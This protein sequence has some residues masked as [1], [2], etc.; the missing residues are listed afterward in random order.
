M[1]KRAKQI[2]IAVLV[3]FSMLFIAACGGNG[4][5]AGGDTGD[6]PEAVADGEVVEI[7]FGN[8]S[9]DSGIAAAYL[10]KEVAERESGGTLQINLFNNN[11][12][13]DD[14]SQIEQTIFGDIHIAVSSSS[15][16]ASMHADLFAFD[17]PFLFFNEAQA[18]TV[19]DGPYG[20]QILADMADIGLKGLGYW[21]NGFRNFTSDHIPVNTPADVAGVTI[22]TM[23]NEIHLAAW[24]AFGANPTPM[25]MTE[26]FTALQQGTI[27]AQE[28]T[29]GTIDGFGLY[30]IQSYISMTGHIYTPFI[31]VMNMDKWNSLNQV[32]QDA[33]MEATRQSID[34]QREFSRNINDEFIERWEEIG[35]TM[36]WPTDTEKAMF[37]VL[38][39]EAGVWDMIRGNMDNPQLLDAM[40]DQLN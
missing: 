8:I 14:R 40:V 12:L 15:P 18:D 24:N 26:V 2:I 6:A 34:Y 13:G 11:V 30:E 38:A 27:D 39:E 19:L 10:F 36:V 9:L 32:Q 20:Q 4:D 16:I 17:A 31:V 25:A 23:E 3:A 21:E 1:K 37:Q 35:V 28:N 5:T 33:I 7:T 29:M 22:R